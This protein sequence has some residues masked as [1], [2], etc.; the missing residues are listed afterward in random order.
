MYKG[1]D[2]VIMN[3]ADSDNQTM[4]QNTATQSLSDKSEGT[5]EI[6]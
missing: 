4:D 3:D 6:E 1:E 2:S 5:P